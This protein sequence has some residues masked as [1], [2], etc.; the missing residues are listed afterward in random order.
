MLEQDI[1][2]KGQIQTI[3]E[4][5]KSNNKE[6]KVKTIYNSKVYARESDSGHHL[7]VFYYLILWKGYSKKENT[8]EPALVVL[9]L[10]K[11]I[12]TFYYDHP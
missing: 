12:I 9:Y 5:N 1:I 3:L 4:V 11:R 10:Y 6:Y 2:K 7:P 8:W